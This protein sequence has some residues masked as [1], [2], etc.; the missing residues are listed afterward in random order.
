MLRF[1]SHHGFAIV[2]QPLG[3]HV[4]GKLDSSRAGA[5]SVARLEHEQLAFLDGELEVLHVAVV[6]L[7]PIRDRPQFLVGLGKHGAEFGDR[8]GRAD[9][10]DHILALR[11]EQELAVELV[12][13]GGRVTRESDSRRGCLPE[14]AEH[15]GLHVD[16][17]AEIVR[18][19]V[20]AAVVVGA[21]VVP[22]A[23]D[24]VAGQL[25]LLV[26]VLREIRALRL[27]VMRLERCHDYTQLRGGQIHVVLGS[28]VLLDALQDLLELALRH[29]HDNVAEHHDEAPVAVESERLLAAEPGKPLGCLVIQ[30]EVEDRV[31]H[32]GH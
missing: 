10:G 16:G 29:V 25:E 7:Q 3:N 28:E 1:D 8:P 19:V 6:L 31:H 9:A 12:G 32:A 18:D 24:R 15:H 5:L 14:I 23:E 27:F 11:V 17:R 4:H 30:P 26:G 20:H 21:R 13:T 22:G 2:D